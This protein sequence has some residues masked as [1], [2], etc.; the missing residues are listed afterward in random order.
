MKLTDLVRSFVSE[1]AITAL[2]GGG[3]GKLDGI[4]TVGLALS[5][6]PF[7]M[8]SL[9]G[10]VQAYIL[11]AGVDAEASP[12]IIR[13]DDFDAGTNAKVWER[14][15]LGV[16]PLLA[17]ELDAPIPYSFAANPLTGFWHDNS[18]PE[19]ISVSINGNPVLAITDAQLLPFGGSAAAPSYSFNEIGGDSAGMWFDTPNL[20]LHL[21]VGGASVLKLKLLE[22]RVNAGV[23]LAVD[24]DAN[25]PAGNAVLVA[26]TKHVANTNVSVGAVIIL[27]RKTA[28]GAIGDLTYTIDG[29]GGGFTINSSSGTD[30]STVSYLIINVN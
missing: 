12:S 26:G 3:A 30:T 28:G 21:A 25:A 27:S 23:G 6:V 8:F 19:S 17:P 13:P 22:L 7:R 20:S 11:R 24:A 2:T 16:F 29:G 10:A 1:R 5:P 4:A 9:G 18:A 15:N 14:V